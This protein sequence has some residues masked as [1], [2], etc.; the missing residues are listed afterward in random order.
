MRTGH[1]L[2]FALGS[3][4]HMTRGTAPITSSSGTT[5]VGTHGLAPVQTPFVAQTA[6]PMPT[7]ASHSGG[8]GRIWP[9]S[10]ITAR[11]PM[12]LLGSTRVTRTPET[13][14]CGV[15]KL[16]WTATLTRIRA[17]AIQ[18]TAKRMGTT[19]SATVLGAGPR[20]A[21]L[22]KTQVA[23]GLR[24]LVAIV[25]GYGEAFLAWHFHR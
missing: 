20:M 10:T 17:I 16:R 13:F 22:V 18:H 11:R 7:R 6:A 24:Y 15:A 2:L 12:S 4:V 25:R 8:L 23:I 21:R 19:G 14:R 1:K 5:L 3:I 9:S